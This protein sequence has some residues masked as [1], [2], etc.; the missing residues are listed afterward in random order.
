MPRYLFITDYKG[1]YET[2]DAD[3]NSYTHCGLSMYLG[4][5]EGNTPNEA[6]ASLYGKHSLERAFTDISSQMVYCFAINGHGIDVDV[7]KALKVQG[8]QITNQITKQVSNEIKCEWCGDDLPTNGAARFSHLKKHIRE[9]V[10]KKLLT[11]E[12]ANLIRKL[13]LDNE[14]RKIC[15]AHFKKGT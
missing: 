10:K 6:F 3:G 12:Q 9:L 11:Q 14:I 8:N 2:L 4:V 7:R 5:D 13:D 15:I 1:S